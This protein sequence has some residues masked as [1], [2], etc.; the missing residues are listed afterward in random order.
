MSPSLLQNIDTEGFVHLPLDDL[1]SFF[2][3]FIWICVLYPGPGQ[4]HE[5]LPELLVHWV[6]GT[7]KSIAVFK[8]GN[9]GT[10]MFR[11]TVVNNFTPYF[12]DLADFAD[13]FR[14]RALLDQNIEQHRKDWI[15]YTTPHDHVIEL[16]DETLAI[17]RQKAKISDEQSKSQPQR[18][19]VS[20]RRASWEARAKIQEQLTPS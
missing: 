4:P 9:T 10:V 18:L 6:Q 12:Q 8:A 20:S 3:V 5:H 15:N 14:R 13:E 17:L 2:F 1:Q 19:P 7:P 11:A 16:F